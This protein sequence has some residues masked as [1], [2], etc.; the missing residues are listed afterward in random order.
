MTAKKFFL[1]VLLILL[2]LPMISAQPPFPPTEAGSIKIIF[3]QFDNFMFDENFLLHFH[4]HDSNNTL[5]TN[6]TT[7]CEF[8]LFNRTGEHII[9]Q[10]HML[11]DNDT[12]DFFVEINT[13]AANIVG[14]YGYLVYCNSTAPQWGTLSTGFEITRRQQDE[15][16]VLQAV[17]VVFIMIIV[18]FGAM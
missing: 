14:D 13:S 12:G 6:L 9:V 10:T 3:P 11:F 8:H 16:E 5:L 17:G 1:I 15:G 2:V 7:Q 4:V 18:Y